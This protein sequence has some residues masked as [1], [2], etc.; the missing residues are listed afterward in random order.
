MHD[1]TGDWPLMQQAVFPV[2]ALTHVRQVVTH[3]LGPV[4]PVTFLINKPDLRRRNI[5]LE[6]RTMFVIRIAD[7]RAM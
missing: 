5:A 1:E 4:G 2:S 6:I 7:A 3:L